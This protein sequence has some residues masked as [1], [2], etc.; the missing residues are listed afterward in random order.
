M[1]AVINENFE[2]VYH[3]FENGVGDKVDFVAATS[4]GYSFGEKHAN[5]SIV[6]K[7]IWEEMLF[8]NHKPIFYD[9]REAFDTANKDGIEVGLIYTYLIT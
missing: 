3:C 4:Q 7:I 9:L 2:S 6:K 5:I 8:E 1:G